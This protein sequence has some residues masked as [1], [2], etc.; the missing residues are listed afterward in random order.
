MGVPKF[1]RWISERYPC[2]SELVK[3]YQIPEYDNLYLDMNGII[4]VCSHPNDNDPHFRMTEE[5]MIQD[6]FHYIEVLFRLIQPKKVFF[7]AIDGVA[8]RAKMNQQRSRRFRSAREAVVADQKA[9]ERGEVLPTEERFDSNCIT[10][11]TEFMNNLDKQL[12]YFV[13]S[14]MSQDRLWQGCTVIYSGHETPG[15]GEHKIME[16]IR[17]SKSQAGYDPNTRH[18]LYGLDA[19]LMMLGLTSHEP[20]F[21]LLR[22]EV[23]FGGKEANKRTPTPEATTFHLLHLSLM[24]EYVNYEFSSLKE[25]IP[26]EYNLENI[27]DDWSL[28]VYKTKYISLLAH[29]YII[30]GI[31]PLIHIILKKVL[32]SLDGYLHEGGY[33]NLKRF[34]KFMEKLSEFD[35]EKFDEENADLKFFS[36]K[37]SADAWQSKRSVDERMKTMQTFQFE[38]DNN[39]NMFG[40][41]DHLDDQEMNVMAKE[42]LK[43][44]GVSD[45]PFD[46]D[47]EDEEESEK[48]ENE[49]EESLFESE[50]RQ[51]KQDYYIRKMNF[52]KVTKHVLYDQ[53]TNYVRAIQWILHYYYN[54]IQSWSWFYPHHY[55]PYI[56][57]VR[58]FSDMKMNF[59]M[60]QPFMPNEQLLGVLPPLSKKLL[61]A[62]YRGLMVNEDSPLLEFY[63]EDFQTDMNGKA[64]DWE[65]VVLIPFIDQEMMLDAMKPCNE[66]LTFEERSR[67]VHSPMYIYKYTSDNLGEYKAPKYFPPIGVNHAVCNRL[68][69]NAWEIE[70]MRIYKGLCKGA[71]LDTY[72]AGFPTL[73][74]LKHT[75]RVEKE[76][77]KVFQQPSRGENFILMVDNSSDAPH[78]RDAARQLLGK[79]IFV[80]WPHLV[81]AKYVAQNNRVVYYI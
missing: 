20:N 65:A 70:P 12:Q 80:S 73:Q 8:P 75:F 81:E 23:R 63:P 29:R 7:M 10:P 14:K 11:G 18:C 77:V 58:N 35:A 40:A 16:Y 1:Y 37:R 27:V 19:D 41:L 49:D 33:L 31:I 76:G 22:E 21:S 36:A 56:S 2:L 74:H 59:D 28:V 44:L 46:D 53:A 64:Q 60:G 42:T 68:D 51:H 69:R 9:I 47:S 30:K 4:H 3:E 52:E 24:R 32:P 25:T 48:D 66:R 61:P 6:I 39:E 34:E 38:D 50:F 79:I 57:D 54:G 67:N 43:R 55:A 13:T 26:F 5:K 62:V 45:N 15:E 17:F 72:F 78:I 71:K